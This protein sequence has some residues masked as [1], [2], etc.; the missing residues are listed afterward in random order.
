MEDK[1]LMALN[2]CSS[3]SLLSFAV[4]RTV[5]IIHST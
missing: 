5:E 3:R 2:P 4:V 1:D